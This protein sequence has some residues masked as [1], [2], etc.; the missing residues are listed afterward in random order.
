MRASLIPLILVLLLPAAPAGLDADTNLRMEFSGNRVSMESS[1]TSLHTVFS[2]LYNEKG[3]R[4]FAGQ[5]TMNEQVKVRFQD[6]TMEEGLRRILGSRNF[7]FTF[8]KDQQVVGVYVFS[9]PG[10]YPS[11]G[12]SDTAPAAVS[13]RSTAPRPVP[14][15]SRERSTTAR[16]VPRPG[17]STEGISAIRTHGPSEPVRGRPPHAPIPPGAQIHRIRSHSSTGGLE[18]LPAHGASRRPRPGSSPTSIQPL[19]D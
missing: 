11:G 8:D 7:S 14:A 4:F 10:R 12:A 6:L 1:E 15:A 2:R 19:Q 13:V 18:A 9:A 3:I 17:Q 16:V 5:D